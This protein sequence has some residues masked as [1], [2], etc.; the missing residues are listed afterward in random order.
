L[1]TKFL[2]ERRE[3]KILRNSAYVL[4]GGIFI[5]FGIFH[6]SSSYVMVRLN[7][8]NHLPSMTGS[9]GGGG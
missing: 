1:Y 5:Y 8:E 2:K 4:L 3:K 9:V 6:I 7:T